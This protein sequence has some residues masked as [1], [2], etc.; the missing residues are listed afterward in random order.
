MMEISDPLCPALLPCC[1]LQD[2][3]LHN[4]FLSRLPEVFMGMNTGVACSGAATATDFMLSKWQ[5]LTRIR[6]THVVLTVLGRAL[7]QGLS[8]HVKALPTISHYAR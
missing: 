3:L 4:L 6:S 1:Q 2:V 8:L 7:R 5:A